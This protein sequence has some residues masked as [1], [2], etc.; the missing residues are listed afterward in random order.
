[1]NSAATQVHRAQKLQQDCRITWRRTKS[2]LQLLDRSISRIELELEGALVILQPLGWVS[3]AK[4][5]A[6]LLDID[7]VR[8]QTAQCGSLASQQAL[9]D[10]MAALGLL[11]PLHAEAMQRAV[12]SCRR[13]NH[14]IKSLLPLGVVQFRG[15]GFKQITHLARFLA[16]KPTVVNA[17]VDKQQQ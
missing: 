13:T 11:Q 16:E 17:P 6:S 2:L 7:V 4:I 10:G 14:L 3:T 12:D 8:A 1:M 15:G 5:I 9:T